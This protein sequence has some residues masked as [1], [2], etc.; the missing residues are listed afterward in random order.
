MSFLLKTKVTKKQK[1]LYRKK[2]Q[3][4]NTKIE[5]VNSFRWWNYRR[6]YFLLCAFTY[7]AIFYNK[8][9]DL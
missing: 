5:T 7:L 4:M 3:R 2:D 6:F 9:K 8:Y 1:K